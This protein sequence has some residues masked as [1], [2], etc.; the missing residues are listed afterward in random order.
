MLDWDLVILIR[1]FYYEFKIWKVIYG[2]FKRF[3]Y[4]LFI[5]VIY[6]GSCFELEMSIFEVKHT[7]HLLNN[8]IYVEMSFKNLHC[9]N[10][11]KLV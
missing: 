1:F 8:R 2:V 5:E 9:T 7:M 4:Y 3:L 6:E 11:S 10:L